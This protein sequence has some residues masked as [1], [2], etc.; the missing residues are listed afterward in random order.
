VQRRNLHRVSHLGTSSQSTSELVTVVGMRAQRMPNKS[1]IGWWQVVNMSGCH[2][3]DQKSLRE[4]FLPSR[5]I[6]PT[7]SRERDPMP[8][9]RLKIPS[10]LNE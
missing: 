5:N 9:C 1:F 8:T 4:N 2:N 6:T 3:N 7:R 10:T